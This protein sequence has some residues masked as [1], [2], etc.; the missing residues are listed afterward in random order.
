MIHMGRPAPF[1]R[2]RR[3][4]ITSRGRS[5]SFNLSKTLPQTLAEAAGTCDGEELGAAPNA[6]MNDGQYWCSMMAHDG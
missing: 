1:G 3:S 2:E 6:M 5:G 4:S